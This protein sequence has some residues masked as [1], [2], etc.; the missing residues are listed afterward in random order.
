MT[1]FRRFL[2]CV[3]LMFWQGGFMF[4]GAV[5]VPV[6]A[7]ILGSDL[8]Q[9]MITRQVTHF[10]HLAGGVC[11]LVW[12]W[13]VL[14]EQRRTRRALVIG[15]MTL[16]MLFL[17][18]QHPRM[19]ALIDADVWTIRDRPQFRRMHQQYLL[20]SSAQWLFALIGLV[21]SLRVWSQP[22]RGSKVT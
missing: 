15:L 17:V 6:G 13:D 4:Y 22:A 2:L 18:W 7:S 1:L 8:G 19:D 9:G 20:A 10:L 12:F 14:C 21:Q 3:T 11:L 5:V 16:L